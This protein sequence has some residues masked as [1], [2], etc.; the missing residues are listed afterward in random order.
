[1]KESRASKTATQMALSRAIETRLPEGVRACADPFAEQLVGPAYRFVVRTRPIRA[2]VPSL[3]ERLFPGHHHYVVARTA[4]F[5]AALEEELS[6]GLN[7]LV[8][9]GAGLDSR[10]YRFASRL[11]D[12]PV[13]EVD[14]PA[15]S[16]AKRQALARVLGSIPLNVRHVA[17]DFVRDDLGTMLERAGYRGG[18][19]TLFLWEGT[20]PYLTSES[21]AGTLGFV[22]RRSASGSVIVFDYV[23]ASVL[24]GSCGMR[25]AQNE[26][27]RMVR[28]DEP[29]TFGIEPR[30]LGSFLSGLGF[31]DANDVGGDELRERFFPPSRR[32]VYVKPWWRI[33]RAVVR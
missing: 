32:S 9:L 29:F 1:V 31:R 4:Y 16:R 12:I 21:V 25:G 22:A 15:T 27:D 17:I 10:A 23:L 2:I 5:D 11:G 33:A 18:V 14:H 24:D 30:S 19:R 28:T 7:Q 20:T 6:R 8:V 26:R 3:I 13:F